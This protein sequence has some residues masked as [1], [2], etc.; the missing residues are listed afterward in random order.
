MLSRRSC[1]SACVRAC[2]PARFTRLSLL[3]GTARPEETTDIATC[4]G[5]FFDK[6]AHCRR[7]ARCTV[8]AGALHFG[9][10]P[11]RCPRD[12]HQLTAPPPARTA[13]Q[14]QLTP[15]Q[16]PCNGQSACSDRATPPAEF[17][18][19]HSAQQ[20][21]WVVVCA[22]LA[23][24]RKNSVPRHPPLHQPPNSATR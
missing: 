16:Q 13:A 6:P 2:V 4:L 14:T 22:T 10:R 8:C 23:E 15:F 18:L 3:P 19:H 11:S 5:S 1:V 20:Y 24:S 21:S 17:Q 7:L 12:V 9:Y